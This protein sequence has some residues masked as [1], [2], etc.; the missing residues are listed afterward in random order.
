[1][2]ITKENREIYVFEDRSGIALFREDFDTVVIYTSSIRRT[3]PSLYSLL[4]CQNASKNQ[5]A[6]EVN[7]QGLFKVDYTY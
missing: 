2:T 6:K 3:L 4:N 1:M 5:I 7:A